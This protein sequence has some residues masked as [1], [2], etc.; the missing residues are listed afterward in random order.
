M[1]KRNSSQGL[2]IP[3]GEGYTEENPKVIKIIDMTL[4]F[5]T[6]QPVA[7]KRLRRRIGQ[8]TN[9]TRQLKKSMTTWERIQMDMRTLQLAQQ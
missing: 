7:Y 4:L 2:S 1:V 9:E 6:G 8:L 3:K 5:S